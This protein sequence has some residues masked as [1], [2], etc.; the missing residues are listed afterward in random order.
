[1]RLLLLV[2]VAVALFS[3]AH[4]SD[5]DEY[6]E[7]TEADLKL[8]TRASFQVG[9]SL[10]LHCTHW[11]TSFCWSTSN[12]SLFSFF[13]IATCFLQGCQIQGGKRLFILSLFPVVRAS[14]FQSC[15]LYWTT[16]TSYLFS[17]ED[18]F[19]A[20][21]AEGEPTLN[22]WNDVRADSHLHFSGFC[23]WFTRNFFL[24]YDSVCMLV[25]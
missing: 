1:M 15:P 19:A 17:P 16:L 2:F 5:G 24:I 20:T 10:S 8:V 12:A 22:F 3:I 7:P 9:A 21:F 18:N 13:F 23:S 14:L 6:W 25:I 11:K 4:A